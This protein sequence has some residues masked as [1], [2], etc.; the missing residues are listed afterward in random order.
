[1]AARVT[2]VRGKLHSCSFASGQNL[3]TVLCK[4]LQP[5]RILPS[6]VSA[7]RRKTIRL[8]GLLQPLWSMPAAP[9]QR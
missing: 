5:L 7:K 9:P 8:P 3:A 2:A 4:L 6:A 1:M